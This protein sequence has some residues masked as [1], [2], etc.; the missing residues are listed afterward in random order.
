M[1]FKLDSILGGFNLSAI[2]ERLKRIEEE[3]NA[4]VLY[5][6]NP[7]GESNQMQNDLDMNGHA[8]LNMSGVL[9]DG[10]P[11]P[12]IVNP[13]PIGDVAAVGS[14]L[15]YARE[16]HVHTGIVGPRGPTGVSTGLVYA[17]QRSIAAPTGSPGTV[18]F[19]F[20]QG[21]IVTPVGLN[22]DNGWTKAIPDGE[23]PLWVA[24]ASASADTETDTIDGA[25]WASPALLAKGGL[26]TATVYIYKRTSTNVAPAVPSLD[27]VYTFGQGLVSNLTNGWT[28]NIPDVSGGDFLWVSTA[29]AAAIA[30]FDTIPTTEWAVP[31]VLG[32]KGDAGTPGANGGISNATVYAYIR[33]ATLP[34]SNP[35]SVTY[36]FSSGSITSPTTLANGWS[37]TIPAGNSP[38]YVVAATASSVNATDSIADTEWTAPVQLVVNGVDGLNTAS[39]YLYRRTDSSSAPTLPSATS[40]YTFAT[41]V[42]AGITNSW[43]QTIPAASGGKYLWVTTATAASLSPTDDIP[44]TEWAVPQVMAQDGAN[45]NSGTNGADGK[46]GTVTIA[47]PISGSAWSDSSANTAISTAGYGTPINRDIVTLYNSASGYSETRF[48]DGT[49]WLALTS[50]ING[51]MLVS[52]TLSANKITGG[53]LSGVS[54]GIGSGNSISGRAFEVSSGG[55]LSV[56]NI[57]GG[58][59][60]FD[61]S[62]SN[63][64]A[65]VGYSNKAGYAGI[66]GTVSSSNASGASHGLVGSNQNKGTS[67]IV[68]AASGF[69]FYADGSGTNYGP[70]TGAH[71]CLIPNAVSIMPGDIVLD[72][73]LVAIGNIS[74]TIFE[75]VASDKAFQPGVGVFVHEVGSLSDTVPSAMLEDDNKT[76]SQDW[77]GAHKLYKRGAMNSLGEGMV[78]VCGQGGNLKNGDLI[79]TSDMSGKG[80]KQPD[81]VIRSY[82]V[83]KVRGDVS[84]NSPDEVQLVPCI[85][86]CG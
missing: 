4:R 31:Q 57:Y 16:D 65:V 39:I 62:Y 43:T 54:I 12:A 60:S 34:T 47:Y 2:N 86:L 78:N 23:G 37:K 63:T 56:D 71:D 73:K 28:S 51:N 26:N 15:R 6:D 80:M 75:V 68:G 9:L 30:T 25:E 69:D 20:T 48:R 50:Y 27:V 66:F 32:K 18:V 1:K 53:T 7:S 3:F 70:F 13:A 49:S 79:C 83:A 58:N 5:R 38:L 29:T 76:P 85:Y 55:V 19:N 24:V 17:Y 33:S 82:T 22:L 72:K 84:F 61:N 77:V 74:N 21:Q 11:T 44:V 64:N 59:A 10:V 81:D 52:G 45:G 35:G 40:T 42:L 36:T 8:I 41:R 46:R 14:S 67:G